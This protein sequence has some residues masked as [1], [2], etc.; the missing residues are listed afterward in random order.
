MFD[1]MI[2]MVR[3]GVPIEKIVTHRF[4]LEEADKAFKV[5]CSP[6]CGKIVFTS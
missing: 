3:R 5:F 1:E 6:E 4:L 2:A